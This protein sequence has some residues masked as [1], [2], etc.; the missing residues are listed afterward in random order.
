MGRIAAAR[1]AVY[2][3]SVRS[4][5]Q[6]VTERPVGSIC[7]H[8]HHHRQPILHNPTKGQIKAPPSFLTSKRVELAFRRSKANPFQ[9]R[10]KQKIKTNKVT[11]L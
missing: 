5:E 10:N 2:M 8:Q 11:V 1:G 3:L 7:I 9:P 4:R 6:Q